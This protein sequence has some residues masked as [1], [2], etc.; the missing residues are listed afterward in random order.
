MFFDYR[1]G[2]QRAR[3]QNCEDS[4]RL[5]RQLLIKTDQG[6]SATSAVIVFLVE[7]VLATTDLPSC[8]CFRV[9][10]GRCTHPRHQIM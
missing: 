4:N 2:H 8:F 5:L 1:S 10:G 7:R 9:D 3:L 6:N